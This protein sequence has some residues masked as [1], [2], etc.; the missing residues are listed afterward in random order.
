MTAKAIPEES[1]V[2][3]AWRSDRLHS[4]GVP[5]LIADQVADRVDWHQVAALIEQGCDPM[6]AVEIAL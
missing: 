1:F 5:V 6:L 3:H 2:V 4:L